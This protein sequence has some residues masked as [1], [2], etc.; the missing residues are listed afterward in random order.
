MERHT[1]PIFDAVPPGV[2]RIYVVRH[3]P[4]ALNSAGRLRGRSE[5]ALD[6]H[7][8]RAAWETAHGLAGAHL[9]A[10]YSSP[11][12]RALEVG[13]AV[14]AVNALG[15]VRPLDGLNNLDY[16]AWEDLTSAEAGARDR[17]LFA[18]YLCDP[19]EA[20]CPGGEPLAA[21][22]DRILGALRAIGRRHA[23]GESV[24][25]VTHGVMVRLAVLRVAGPTDLD[26]QFAIPTS[27]AVAFDVAAG[28]VELT[29]PLNRSDPDP[30]KSGVY[31]FPES[32]PLAV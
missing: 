3:G 26:W 10:V 8:R 2:C 21:A 15:A 24:A 9:R 17:E 13:R 1:S 25:A 12:E 27:A 22:A 4:T 20:V 32:V 18:R 14:S 29:Q 19:L 7:G 30:R 31:L 11:L 28:R 16:G 23:R 5:V 6:A